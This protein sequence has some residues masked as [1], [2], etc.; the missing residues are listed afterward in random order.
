MAENVGEKLDVI[1]SKMA[2]LDEIC[3]AIHKI[4]KSIAQLE[5]RTKDLESFKD[6]SSK[7]LDVLR[8]DFNNWDRMHDARAQATENEL[9]QTKKSLKDLQ[10]KYVELE[11]KT[12]SP[13]DDVA[14]LHTKD[15]YLEAYSRRE[16]I[17]FLNIDED[18]KEDTEATLRGFLEEELGYCD[19][20]TVEIQR[21]HRN[22]RK[23]RSKPRPIIARFL[24]YKDCEQI[25]SLG[26]RLQGTNYSMFTDLPYEIVKRRKLL[27]PAYKKAKKNNI[28]AACSKAKPDKLFIRGKEWPVG[29]ELF[30]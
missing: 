15:L 19:F 2:K 10:M 4:E 9:E 26:K 5:E 23:D 25:L 8:M 21:V 14:E 18:P 1:L 29:Q 12:K 24:R 28:R 27:L 16:N 6:S 17:I 3:S 13:E 30:I 20:D 22:Q 11:M 7:E